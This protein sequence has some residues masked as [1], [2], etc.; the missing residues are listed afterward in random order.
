MSSSPSRASS[1]RSATPAQ[2]TLDDLHPRGDARGGCRRRTAP[3]SILAGLAVELDSTKLK[4]RK[5]M[6]K[7]TCVKALCEVTTGTHFT[8]LFPLLYGAG[9]CCTLTNFMYHVPPAAFRR[10]NAKLDW[11]YGYGTH[12]HNAKVF[13]LF[14]A[15]LTVR[16]IG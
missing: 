1:V 13:V 6:K 7:N 9:G 16:A 15:V 8:A 11:A 5:K 2:A 12:C 3:R 14:K 10:N 4:R